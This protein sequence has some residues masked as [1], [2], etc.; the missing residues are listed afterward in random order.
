MSPQAKMSA[1]MVAALAVVIAGVL[2]LQSVKRDS[3]TPVTDT[4]ASTRSQLVRPDS[5]VLRKRGNKG[6]T[7][8]EFLDF[9]CE[10]CGDAY[11]AIEDLRNEYGGRVTFVA[12]YFPLPNH[13]NAM[14]AARAVEA[15]AQQDRFEDMYHK[16][17]TTQKQWGEQRTPKDDLFLSYAD[18][19][20]LDLVKFDRDYRSAT[21]LARI[22]KDIADGKALGVQGTPSFFVSGTRL[23]PQSY[24]DLTGALDDALAAAN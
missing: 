8:V 9:E 24:T 5:H 14:R 13:F 15:A 23:E 20:G 3:D 12:R 17:Y 18:D 7:F 21:T 19:L 10:A 11:P 6:V 16:M 2:A 1:A 22:K 4:S